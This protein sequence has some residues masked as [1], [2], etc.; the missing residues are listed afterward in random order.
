MDEVTYVVTLNGVV[1]ATYSGP[2]H[3]V[4]DQIRRFEASHPGT[5]EARDVTPS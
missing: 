1:A 2:R 4:L 3:E 5:V